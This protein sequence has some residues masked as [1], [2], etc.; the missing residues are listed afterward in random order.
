MGGGSSSS[1]SES[2]QSAEAYLAQT[3][4]GSC[5]ITCTN[6]QQN[7]NIDIINSI[8][9]G[10]INL[11]QS[12]SVD[13]SCMVSSSSDATSDVLFKATNSTNAKNAGSLF[14]GL[15]NTDT[16][17]SLSRQDIKQTIMQ[18]T[19]EK[20][21]LATLNQMN[22]I[23]ILAANSVIGGSIDI[24]QTGSVQGTCQLQNNMTA[25]A[26]A[27]AMASNTA[28]SGKDKKA[29]KKGGSSTLITI[30]AFIGIMV[31][32]FIIAKM[33]TSGQAQTAKDN[34]LKEVEV[35]RGK[36]G[37]LG[38]VKPIMDK[39]GNPIIDPQTLRPIC[40]PPDIKPV[41]PTFNID[42]GSLAQ[43]K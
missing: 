26:S 43:K 35:A 38:G 6:I 23:T 19:T 30:I 42:L 34:L 36:A 17:Q 2:E 25:A 14:G 39:F 7:V 8:V 9:G 13:A 10:N 27:T 11:T 31:I 4:S 41:A 16:A 22:G 24:G 28:S 12:C 37:C 32:V 15:W 1:L 21:K 3:Y 5:N 29:Q 18:N 33:Y 40:A 20:C